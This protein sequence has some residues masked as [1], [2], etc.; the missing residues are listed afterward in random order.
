[1]KKV[2]YLAKLQDEIMIYSLKHSRTVPKLLT[3]TYTL[4]ANYVSSLKD[5]LNNV[6]EKPLARSGTKKG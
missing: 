2:Y 6:V 5:N 3:E 1:M 4:K